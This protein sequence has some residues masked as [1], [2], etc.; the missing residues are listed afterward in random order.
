MDT[1]LD[2]CYFERGRGI[3]LAVANVKDPFDACFILLACQREGTCYWFSQVI[4]EIEAA[5]VQ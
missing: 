3:K 4:K 1:V 2:G 5:V